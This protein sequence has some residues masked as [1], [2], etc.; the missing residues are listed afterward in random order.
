MSNFIN[1][2]KNKKV[3]EKQLELNKSEFNNS[4]PQHWF[5][6]LNTIKSLNISIG[7]HN[8]QF[9][10]AFTKVFSFNIKWSKSLTHWH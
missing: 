1:N 8:K 5:D 3:F 4:Y 10:I 2:W 7:K 6:F 9:L